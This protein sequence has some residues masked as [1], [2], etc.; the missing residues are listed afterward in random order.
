MPSRWQERAWPEASPGDD[1]RL[2]FETDVELG[3]ELRQAARARG[4]LPEALAADL[5]ARGLEHEARRSR[6][7]A[8]LGALTRRELQ[9]ASLAAD[10]RTNRQIAEA[11]VVSPET[12]KTHIAHV[13]QKLGVRS[14]ADLRV[15]VLDLELQDPEALAEGEG[16]A[17]QGMDGRR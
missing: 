7:E 13:L 4:Q 3:Q 15:F 5:I 17:G 12:V 8:V 2:V 9:V 10:G 1:G 6:A 16:E 11:L 14:K